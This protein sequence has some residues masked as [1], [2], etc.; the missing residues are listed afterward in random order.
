MG[1]DEDE[2]TESMNILKKN[3]LLELPADGKA[4][5]IARTFDESSVEVLRKAIKEDIYTFSHMPNLTDENFAGNASGVAMEY[6]LLGLEMITKEKE[7]WYKKGLKRRIE[8]F[9]NFLNL[10]AI[11]INP[12]SV[13]MAFTRNLPKNLTEISQM[14]ANLSGKVSTETIIEQLPFVEDSALE[15]E[16]VKKESEENVARQQQLF[17]GE[18]ETPFFDE[19]ATSADDQ[20]TKQADDKAD[21]KADKKVN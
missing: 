20:D 11:A 9:C 2:V 14:I 21:K 10:K 3:G 5:Y 15:V 1:D 8:L 16:K 6:K 17:K 13:K 19:D 4:E 18:N 7:K 12:S